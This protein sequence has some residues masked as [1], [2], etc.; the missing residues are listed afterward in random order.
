MSSEQPLNPAQR[1]V[2]ALLGKGGERPLIADDARDHLEHQLTTALAPL[3]ARLDPADPLWLGKHA[4]ASVHACEAN[5]V[6]TEGTFEWTV[7]SVRGTVAH[8]A[9]ELTVN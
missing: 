5:Y 9:I 1:D 3:A 2:I 8:K 6:A 4:L 7:A